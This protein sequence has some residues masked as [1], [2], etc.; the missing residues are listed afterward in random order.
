MDDW[1]KHDD[2]RTYSPGDISTPLGYIE[3]LRDEERRQRELF[4]E[5]PHDLQLTANQFLSIIALGIVG[6]I[7]LSWIF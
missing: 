2:Y 7:I 6:A 3:V 5:T 1:P 4:A